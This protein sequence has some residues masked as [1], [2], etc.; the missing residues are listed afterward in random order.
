M[1]LPL[2][3]MLFFRFL[4]GRDSIE[5]FWNNIPGAT[6]VRYGKFAKL[7]LRRFL[8]EFYVDCVF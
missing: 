1:N 7:A 4:E 6:Q 5:L 8:R 2:K 3:K